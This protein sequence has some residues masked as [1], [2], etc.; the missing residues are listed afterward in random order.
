MKALYVSVI[1]LM[2]LLGSVVTA[3]DTKNAVKIMQNVYDR[4]TGKDMSGTLTMTLKNSRGDLRIRSIKQSIKSE[5]AIEKK[6]MFFTAPADVR[7]TSFM[8]WSYS[9]PGKNDDQWIYLPAL[10][11]I[12][13]ISSS[14]SGDYFMGSDFTYDDLGDRQPNEDTHKI[15]GKET[16][17]GK[18][19]IIVESKSVN[20]GYMYSR[21]ITWVIDS[22]WIGLKKEFY[23]E[24]GELLKT[25]QVKEYK[26][27]N[28]YWT[29]LNTEMYNAQ[30]D[31]TTI[32]KL[33][34]VKFDTGIS[35]DLFSERTMQR[36]L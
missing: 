11:R 28:G 15:I 3:E 23:D 27:I 35:D 6:L 20:Q 34:D 8:S 2:T 9:E 12:K 13:R 32:M 14:G 24:Q 36:G 5:K 1:S 18:K 21:T 7:N 10:K 33:A 17:D 26:Q 19:C 16:V 22:V 4:P 30:K 25:L 29:V 31:H